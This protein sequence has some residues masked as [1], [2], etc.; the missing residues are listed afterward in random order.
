MGLDLENFWG[1]LKKKENNQRDFNDKIKD[2]VVQKTG[3]KLKDGEFKVQNKTLYLSVSSSARSAI[4]IKHEQILTLLAD[5]L[6]R[7]APQE[8]I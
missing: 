6:G 3:Y 2:A 7:A 1:W 8:I 5:S 4:Y